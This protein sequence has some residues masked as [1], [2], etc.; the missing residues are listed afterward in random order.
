MT[1]LHSPALACGR[2]TCHI[3]DVIDWPYIIYYNTAALKITYRSVWW[4]LFLCYFLKS[5]ILGGK[6]PWLFSL[7]S[8]FIAFKSTLFN[9]CSPKLGLT[10]IFLFASTTAWSSNALLSWNCG[11]TFS[12]NVS[13]ISFGSLRLMLVCFFLFSVSDTFFLDHVWGSLRYFSWNFPC[14]RSWNWS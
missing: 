2:R 6:A 11:Y 1:C 13:T 4:S 5:H 10:G 8:Y 3:R 7:T 9:H 12:T 14:Q